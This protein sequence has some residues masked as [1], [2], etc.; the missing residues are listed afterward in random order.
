MD[1]VVV[2]RILKDSF[3]T[4]KSTNQDD[5]F[6]MA[7]NWIDEE[8]DELF[9][10]A[11]V[12]DE[13]AM[14]ESSDEEVDNDD[15]YDDS[16]GEEDDVIMISTTGKTT[17]RK[18]KPSHVDATAAI[19]ILREYVSSINLSG[20]CEMSLARLQRQI[21]SERAKAVSQQPSI[22][23]IFPSSKSKK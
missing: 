13:L 8:D 20:E 22:N 7:E 5:L 2:A 10:D 23:S 3:V 21:I 18:R 15:Y 4:D 11:I 9:A 14:L 12:D 1:T 17:E 19:D 6:E 16:E